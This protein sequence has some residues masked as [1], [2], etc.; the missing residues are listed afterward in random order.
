M[1][2]SLSVLHIYHLDTHL[3]TIIKFHHPAELNVI[4]VAEGTYG[5]DPWPGSLS[6]AQIWV[7]WPHTGAAMLD[8]SS[9]GADWY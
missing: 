5:D 2:E 6:S 9:V 1:L 4:I 3:F 8:S 7:V